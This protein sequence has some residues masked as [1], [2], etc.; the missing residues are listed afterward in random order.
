MPVR[1]LLALV[2]PLVPAAA[3]IFTG[4]IFGPEV[5][6]GPYK[7]PASLCA[8]DNGG[9]LPAYYGGEGEYAQS[10]AVFLPRLASGARRWTLPVAVARDPYRSVGNGVCWQDPLGRVWLFCVIRFGPT[11]S[12]SRITAKVSDDPGRERVEPETSSFCLIR[13]PGSDEW[14]PSGRIR[15]ANGNLQPSPVELPRAI[16]LPSSGVGAATAPESAVS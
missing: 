12:T 2:P 9:L 15:S 14:R 13:D 11:W 4:R 16:C 8:L 1:L 6:T 10:T 7:H 3:D 5:P